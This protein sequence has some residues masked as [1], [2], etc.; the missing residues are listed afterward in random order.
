VK[1]TVQ[2]W[3][4]QTENHSPH[5]PRLVLKPTTK[6]ETQISKHIKQRILTKRIINE[7]ILTKKNHQR[8][9]PNNPRNAYQATIIVRMPRNT[10]QEHHPNDYLGTTI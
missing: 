6:K 9:S 1:H 10:S 7:H 3:L 4:V 8:T 5:L 2:I